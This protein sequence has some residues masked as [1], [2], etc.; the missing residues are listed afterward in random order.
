MTDPNPKTLLLIGA[1]RGIGLAMAEEFTKRGWK[2][3]GT[4]RGS[5]RTQLHE[6]AARLA[7]PHRD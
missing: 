2:V 7:K 1:S 5:A 3:V 4:V 6:L